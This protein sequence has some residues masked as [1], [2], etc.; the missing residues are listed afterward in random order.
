MGVGAG[1]PAL[2]RHRCGGRSAST[3]PRPP[4]PVPGHPS[5]R[6]S[7]RPGGIFMKKKEKTV[8]EDSWA[9][10]PTIITK[11]RQTTREDRGPHTNLPPNISRLHTPQKSRG[12]V[13]SSAGLFYST[14]VWGGPQVPPAHSLTPDRRPPTTPHPR[15]TCHGTRW[16][17]I[18]PGSSRTPG[19][20][21]HVLRDM[22]T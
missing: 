1:G 16:P 22:H 7:R 5:C 12:R 9:L 14:C 13:G 15:G 4:D 6:A 18:A 17:S 3:H 21:L 11:G 8:L 19:Y 20:A 10:L 2:P